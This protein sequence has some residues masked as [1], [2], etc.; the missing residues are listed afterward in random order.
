MAAGTKWK[1]LTGPRAGDV[2]G[3]LPWDPEKLGWA[4]GPC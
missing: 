4:S 1:G 3:L 2:Y